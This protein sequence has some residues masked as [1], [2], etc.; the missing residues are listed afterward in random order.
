M[1]T[2]VRNDLSNKLIHLTRDFEG[3]NGRDRIVSI[4]VDQN[5]KG[6]NNDIRGGYKC[7]CFSE[8]PIS[9]IGLILANGHE[10]IR[11]SPYGLIFP[12]EYLFEVG[13]RPVIYQPNS[14]YDL[15]PDDLKYRHVRF[16]LFS[17]KK[18]NDFT[19]EREW[20]IKTEN[21][22]IQSNAVTIIVPTRDEMKRVHYEHA[23]KYQEKLKKTFAGASIS[24]ELNW[25]YLILEDLGVTF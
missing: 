2:I 1:T 12:K 3:I 6:S 19:W 23:A 7:V 17:D 10:D 22:P 21:L 8:A 11:Y 4:L 5:L 24:G 13:A 15:L 9:S 20:R 18:K 14:D 16:E 25:H